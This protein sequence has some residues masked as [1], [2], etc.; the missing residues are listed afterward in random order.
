MLDDER[1]VLVHLQQQQQ[2]QLVHQQLTAA[3]SYSSP[4]TQ[5]IHAAWLRLCSVLRLIVVSS[6]LPTQTD[7]TVYCRVIVI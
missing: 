7:I 3:A 6:S 5:G 1:G 2:Q 4:S